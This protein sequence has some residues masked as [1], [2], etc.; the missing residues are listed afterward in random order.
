MGNPLDET[1]DERLKERLLAVAK[2]QLAP[3]MKPKRA[4]CPKL[5]NRIP[6]KEI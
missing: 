3:Q 4:N 2:M 1:V 6:V 5:N